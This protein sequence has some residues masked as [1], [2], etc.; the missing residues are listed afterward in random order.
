M[1]Q[2]EIIGSKW[3]NESYSKNGSYS[4]H[5]SYSNIHMVRIP[6]DGPK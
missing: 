6:R 2:N 1:D 3:K 5:G 4:N